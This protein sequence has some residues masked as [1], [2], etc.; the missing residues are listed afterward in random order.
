MKNLFSLILTLLLLAGCSGSDAPEEGFRAVF[1][2]T[3]NGGDMTILANADG[4]FTAT[5]KG[6]EMRGM[7]IGDQDYFIFKD[8]DKE[9]VVDLRTVGELMK[10]AI[11]SEFLELSRAN[12]P[13]A[14]KLVKGDE[15]E[16]NGRKG[17]GYR[18]E[19]DDDKDAPYFIVISEDPKLAPLGKVMAKQFRSSIA[20]NP[21]A[22][23]GMF[24]D[25]MKTVESGA[26]IKL[27]DA[28]L[29]EFEAVKA[30]KEITL[31]GKPL[32]KEE[33]RKLLIA[34][35]MIPE[36]PPEVPQEMRDALKKQ[37]AEAQGE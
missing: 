31:P 36:K 3:M 28:S 7:H 19:K 2:G 8:G 10:E 20:V 35:K 9:V 32:G 30:P 33:A 21:I 34:R 1:T 17:I 11:P 16:V 29:T 27:G 18:S 23:D 5:I 26:P 37:K 24:D 4:D 6:Q 14:I 15:I 12:S 25:V 22:P 13:P